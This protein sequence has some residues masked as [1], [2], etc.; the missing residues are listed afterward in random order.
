MTTERPDPDY[1]LILAALI[2]SLNLAD[3]LG[4]VQE[5]VA[6]AAKL[7]GFIPDDYDPISE[8]VYQAIEDNVVSPGL[9][10]S[11]WEINGS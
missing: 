7:A 5:S 9:W 11:Y 10:D 6:R 3:H 1:K 8:T 2:K 4:D